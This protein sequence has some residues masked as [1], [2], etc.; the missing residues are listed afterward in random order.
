MFELLSCV[1]SSVVDS[2]LVG[3]QR[4]ALFTFSMNCRSPRVSRFL[5]QANVSP[6]FP[7]AVDCY[8]CLVGSTCK[9]GCVMKFM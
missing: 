4:S 8:L 1:V 2:T 6:Q 5:A 7:V 9:V 3:K